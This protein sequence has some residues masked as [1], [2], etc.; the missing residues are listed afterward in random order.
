MDGQGR[1]RVRTINRAKVLTGGTQHLMIGF[2][3]GCER[4]VLRQAAEA[5]SSEAR[6]LQREIRVLSALS[7][8]AVPH[9]RLVASAV[10]GDETVGPTFYL[11]EYVEGV[12]LMVTELRSADAAV[13]D[14]MAFGMASALASLTKVGVENGPCKAWDGL[15]AS[16]LVSP[17]GG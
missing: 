17:T 16:W 13:T 11:V 12:N 5:G 6:V 14:A 4:Y 1:C 7:G 10:D 8:S 2:E 15:M 3:R 9:A